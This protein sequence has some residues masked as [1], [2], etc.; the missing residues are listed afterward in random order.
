MKLWY[1]LVRI[2]NNGQ[3]N[4][5]NLFSRFGSLRLLLLAKCVGGTLQLLKFL[6]DLFPNSKALRNLLLKRLQLGGMVAFFRKLR[7]ELGLEFCQL[8]VD[9]RDTLG[10]GCN[11]R[12][13]FL[14][15]WDI[16]VLAQIPFLRNE[17]RTFCSSSSFALLVVGVSFPESFAA[18]AAGPARA[19]VET[20]GLTACRPV[21]EEDVVATLA[22]GA[23]VR[24][25]VV[26]GATDARALAVPVVAV[27]GGGTTDVLLAA[28]EA[29]GV[30]L[31]VVVVVVF[32]AVVV[33][34]GREVVVV[35]FTPVTGVAGLL[36]AADAVDVVRLVAPGAV[37]VVVVAGLGPAVVGEVNGFTVVFAVTD[38]PNVP[39][40]MI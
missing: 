34:E 37:V 30:G 15:L 31:V 24:A 10:L 21:A 13:G 6:L 19:V 25:V 12:N 35:G 5:T 3:P 16:W 11:V 4:T 20:L 29:A 28:A 2:A 32:G 23:V 17:I 36:D 39:E 22:R 18:A 14:K 7:F 38:G 8:R 26:V 27:D 40:L 1:K 33:A 9:C